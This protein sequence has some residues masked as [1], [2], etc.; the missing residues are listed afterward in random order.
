MTGNRSIWFPGIRD[1]LGKAHFEYLGSL[2]NEE[3][4]NKY[5]LIHDYNKFGSL[6]NTH[7]RPSVERVYP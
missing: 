2:H 5:E 6:N 7:F 3:N 4:K 1:G